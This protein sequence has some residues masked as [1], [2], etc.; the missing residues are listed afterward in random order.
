VLKARLAL[1]EMVPDQC[2]CRL[3]EVHA[4][5]RARIGRITPPSR[6]LAEEGPRG[7]LGLAERQIAENEE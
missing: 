6:F 5:G 7:A 2:R 4:L 3:G 1:L